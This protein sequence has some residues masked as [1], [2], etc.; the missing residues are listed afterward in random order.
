MLL[1]QSSTQ[2]FEAILLSSVAAVLFF[3]IQSAVHASSDKTRA[4]STSRILSLCLAPVALFKRRARAWM[5]LINGPEQIQEAYD[6]AKGKPFFVDVPENRYLVVSSWKHIKEIDAAPDSVLSLQGAAKEILQP[7]YTMSSFNWLDKRGAEGTP[8]IRTLRTMLTNHLPDVLP[9]IRRAMS[10]LLDGMYASHPVINGVK[11]S[12]LYPMVIKSISHSNALAFFGEDLVKNEKFMKAATLFIEQTLLIAEVLRLLPK[13]FSNPIGKFLSSRLNSSK[14]IFDTLH[15][16]AAE[17][18]DEWAK[19]K[20]GYDVPERKDCIQWVMES[21]PKAKPWTAERIVYELIA[22][23]FGSVHI[24]STTV[25]FALHDLCLHP[26]YVEP[27]RKEIETAGW[28]KFDKSGGKCFP[29]LDSFMKESARLTPVESVSTRR[30]A[31]QPFQ[32]S[33]GPKIDVGQ[34]VCTAARGMMNDAAFF[35]SPDEFHG[36]RFA[37]PSLLAS[38]AEKNLIPAGLVPELTNSAASAF[39]DISDWQLWGTGK[40]ACPGRYYASAVMKIMLGLFLTKYDMQLTDRDAS[41]HF[42]WRTFIY[43]YEGT[44]AILTPREE[45]A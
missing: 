20:L 41:R 21:A 39:T 40:C 23:W 44:T 2:A 10:G 17:R 19:A 37:N 34:W 18:I 13:S 33:D 30:M 25:C 29:L 28:D 38:A 16:I 4:P 45:A 5:F 32:L 43:P 26:E 8:L 22:L 12:Q 31:L 6:K 27:L 15:P 24:T 42:A 9:D 36:F 7:K 3:G 11:T 14:I 1:A 35:A